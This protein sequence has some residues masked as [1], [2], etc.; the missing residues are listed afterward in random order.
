MHNVELAF[1]RTRL[2]RLKESM[3]SGDPAEDV[4][5]HADNLLAMLHTVEGM[6]RLLAD[7]RTRTG[8]QQAL[9]HGASGR[10]DQLVKVLDEILP[11]EEP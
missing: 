4:Q 9:Q 8:L 6:V 7:A 1:V 3:E 5:F 11:T 2:E 10:L